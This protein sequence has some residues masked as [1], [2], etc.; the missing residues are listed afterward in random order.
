LVTRLKRDGVK[1]GGTASYPRIE[2]H[3][4]VESPRLDK[5]GALRQITATVESM[6]NKSLDEAVNMNDANLRLLTETELTVA[7]GW[8]CIGIVPGQLRDLTETSDTNKI[9]YRL[10]QE[11]SIFLERVKTTTDPEAVTPTS[12]QAEET[13]NNIND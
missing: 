6:S 10:L 7:E 2:V 13:T 12:E 8:K 11:V 3:S 5:E 1:V 4:I 9:L